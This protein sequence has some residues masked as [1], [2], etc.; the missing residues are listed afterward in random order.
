MNCPHCGSDNVDQT[1]KF[2]L[3]IIFAT[4]CSHDFECDDCGCLFQIT[5][6]PIATKIVE[7]PEKEENEPAVAA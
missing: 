2:D 6:H 5:Y 1:G 7:L 3:T 4:E